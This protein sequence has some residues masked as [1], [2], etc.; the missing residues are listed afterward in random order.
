MTQSNDLNRSRRE[1]LAAMAAAGAGATAGGLALT[2]GGT[3]ESSAQTKPD[4]KKKAGGATAAPGRKTKRVVLVVLG[5]GVRTRDCFDAAIGKNADCPVLNAI[6]ADGLLTRSVK[7]KDAGLYGSALTLLTG[8]TQ[9]K[10]KNEARGD[11]PTIFEMLRKG[12]RLPGHQVWL[13]AA[14]ADWHSSLSFANNPS[15]GVR[16]APS[17]IAGDGAFTAELADVT[18]QF[19]EPRIPD[20]AEKDLLDQMQAKI[21]PAVGKAGSALNPG[22]A[23]LDVQE[24]IRKYVLDELSGQIRKSDDPGLRDRMA[25]HYGTNIL[26]VFKPV[27]LTVVTVYH[28]LGRANFDRYQQVLKKNDEQIGRLWDTIKKDPEL[29]GSTSLVIVP[30]MGKNSTFNAKGGIDHSDGGKDHTDVFLIGWGPDFKRGEQKITLDAADVTPTVLSLLG[31]P[32]RPNQGRPAG[33]V[34]E[35]LLNG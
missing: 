23:P 3:G 10:P 9:D 16:F 17:Y 15:W 34:A 4:A 21:D 12:R 29:N 5:G 33:K 19:G 2:A 13:S 18:A 8:V 22:G 1:F 35:A 14:G 28:D 30:D 31:A 7:T 6:A 11:D 26:A 25:L 32:F 20:K 24:R 27:L